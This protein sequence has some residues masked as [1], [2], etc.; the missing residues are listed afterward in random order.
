M[1]LISNS[2]PP[3]PPPFLVDLS[4]VLSRIYI[5]SAS[6][7]MSHFLP[8]FSPHPPRELPT[9]QHVPFSIH[10]SSFPFSI[11]LIRCTIHYPPLPHLH[12]YIRDLQ[13]NLLSSQRY[14]RSLVCGHLRPLDHFPR[15]SPPTMQ[16]S[17]QP[18]RNIRPRRSS[19]SK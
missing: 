11:S 8:S 12:R 10:P 1:T 19:R 3:L 18:F 6:Q 15:P 5:R 9:H 16:D 17:P 13:P 7:N 2:D 4:A 14:P